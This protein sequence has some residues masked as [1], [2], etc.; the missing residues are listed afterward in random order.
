MGKKL[1]NA[2][3]IYGI[4]NFLVSF[5]FGPII[6]IAALVWMIIMI[7]LGNWQRSK[8]RSEEVRDKQT[9]LLKQMADKLDEKDKT[10]PDKGIRYTKD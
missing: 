2:L 5:A 7:A 4:L 9:E 1:G 10:E 3:I 8:G 6:I